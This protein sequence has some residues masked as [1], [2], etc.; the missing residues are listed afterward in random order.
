MHN[1]GIYNE[2]IGPVDR[3]PD[4]IVT[5]A[6]ET[7]ALATFSN[8]ELSGDFYNSTR[9]GLV[10]G[11]FGPPSSVSRNLGLTFVNT[12]ITGVIS[13]STAT[14]IL[15]HIEYP[16]GWDEVNNVPYVNVGH[17]EDYRYLGEVINVPGVPVNNGVIVVLENSTWNVTGT[18]YLTSLT[19]D[20]D[21]AIVSSDGSLVKMTIDSETVEIAPGAYTGMIQLSAE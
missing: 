10:Q 20:E 1:T 21:S 11:P 5:E 6:N 4:H 18:C 16:I 9:G 17:T 3:E 7:D 15:P 13:A 8:I 14:H 19:I 12:D 2:P